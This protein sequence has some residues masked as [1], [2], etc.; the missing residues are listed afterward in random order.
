MANSLYLDTN[1]Y[2]SFYHLTNDDIEEL[3]K[4]LLL[5]KSKELILYLPIQTKDEFYRNRDSKISD[6]LKKFNE[7]KLNKIFPQIVKDYSEEYK[8]MKDSIKSFEKSKQQIIEKLRED[9]VNENLNADKIIQDLFKVATEIENTTEL[10]EKAK[11]RFE[12]GN[13]PGKKGSYGDALNW[14]S[15]LSTV[16]VFD[17]FFFISDDGDYFSE[18]DKNLFNSFLTKEWNDKMPLT[19]FKSYKSLSGF[20]KDNYPN[21]SIESEKRKDNLILELQSSRNFATSRAVLYKL[22]EY[23]DFTKKQLN[24]I[25]EAATSNSQIYWIGTD[26][27]I[28]EILLKILKGNEWKV[29]KSILEEFKSMYIEIHEEDENE[30]PF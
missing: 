23:N 21:I 15:L 22:S 26:Q 16:E 14:E 18:F 4:L 29:E 27:D 6:G 10:I 24:D 2:L 5:V 3:R 25:F 20:L 28:N 30:L 12:F 8:L 7:N 9:V 17:N 19:D 13:P 11:N 1:I